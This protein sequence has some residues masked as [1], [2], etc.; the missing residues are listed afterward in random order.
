MLENRAVHLCL[1]GTGYFTAQSLPCNATGSLGWKAVRETANTFEL[2]NQTN[3][4]CAT[5]YA[6]MVQTA[7]CT[8]LQSATTFW[9][10][11]TVTPNGATLVDD[12]NGACMTSALTV[13]SSGFST[14]AC[15]PADPKQLWYNAG[16]S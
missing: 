11:G 9:R 14:T 2:V 8:S 6:T 1:A 13:G 15:N 4:D 7:P 3:G 10:I 16:T 12:A 5:D